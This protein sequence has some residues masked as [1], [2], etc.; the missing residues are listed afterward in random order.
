MKR[1]ATITALLILTAILLM[2]FGMGKAYADPLVIKDESRGI[3][4]GDSGETPQ[5]DRSLQDATLVYSLTPVYPEDVKE[6]DY[7]P[8]VVSDSRF[9]KIVHSDL[10]N[11]DGRME[12]VITISSTSYA[13]I[14]QGT[15]E[16]AIA[17]ELPVTRQPRRRH[18]IQGEH[19]HIDAPQIAQVQAL[20]ERGRRILHFPER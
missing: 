16:Q 9:F 15:A 19:I 7:E 6:G 13:Y 8:E 12:A 11:R 20:D 10:S 2:P 1:K 4:V 3:G 5:R 17:P 18:A 14:Y